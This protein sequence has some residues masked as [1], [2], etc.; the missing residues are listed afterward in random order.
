[1][2]RQPIHRR[3]LLISGTVVLLVA[4]GTLGYAYL[5]GWPI[6]DGFF[7][8]VITF[9]TVGYGETNELTTA[10]RI[11]TSILIFFCL[12][13]T[14][15]WT[16]TLTSFV[17]E[18]DLSGHFVRRRMSKMIEQTKGHTI[19]CGSG[20]TAHAVIERLLKKRIPVVVVDGDKKRVEALCR[21]FRRLMFVEGDPTSEL[22][23]AK[24]NIM[25][26]SN[27]IAA[28]E[29]EMDNLLIIITCRDIGENIAVYAQSNDASIASRMRK[30]GVDEVISP[31]QLCGD[32][33]VDLIVTT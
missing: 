17:I 21:R 25:T 23:L 30:V 4:A 11:F 2:Q 12:V 3:L 18:N 31:V 22:A 14:T 26:A 33:M 27:V 28:L 9:S 16:A 7:M 5:E 20:P 24:A 19:V 15:C 13:A 6:D 29:S 1:M 32:R 8:T 10:G